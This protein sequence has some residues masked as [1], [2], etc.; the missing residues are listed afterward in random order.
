MDEIDAF[1][2]GI[3]R[4]YVRLA[5]VVPLSTPFTVLIDPTNA[6]NFKCVFCPTGAP[7]LLKAVSRPK[8]TMEFTLFE[9]I[10][11]DLSE[12]DGK[13]KKLQLYKDGEPLLNKR[14]PDMIARAKAANVSDIVELT[15]NGALLNEDRATAL[16][17][18]G[19]DCIRI[20]IEHVHDE[21]Y[22]KITQNYDDFEA[23]RKNV[24]RLFTLK[25]DR[26]SDLSIHVKVVD[27]G[28]TDTDK[29]RF[30]EVFNP[31]SDTINIDAAMDWGGSDTL[32]KDFT[33]AQ[34][35][36]TAMNGV[37]PLRPDRTVCSAPFK[38]MAINFNGQ[39]SVC[40]VDWKMET[41]VGDVRRRSLYNIWNGQEFTQFR[42]THLEGRRDT[43]SACANCGYMQGF[44]DHEDLDEIRAELAAK[45]RTPV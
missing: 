39:V 1:R 28:L 26:R 31:I 2:R 4:N 19:L 29:K 8:G 36:Q 17:D 14:L 25:R 30:Y 5:D 33:V 27:I 32:G 10:I 20:S 22:Q 41:I 15:T 37:T 13:L 11:E 42:L 6:C 43:L 38:S 21:G 9:K 35:S 44:S 12:F 18:A 45:I 3:H 24:E 16:I 34:N 40:C 23:I 7:D